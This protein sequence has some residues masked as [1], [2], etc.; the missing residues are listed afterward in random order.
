MN[1]MKGQHV[2]LETGS[3]ATARAGLMVEHGD[4]V[5]PAMRHLVEAFHLMVGV[6]DD[7][8]KALKTIDPTTPAGKAKEQFC[9]E[10]VRAS[11]SLTT[12]VA[13]IPDEFWLAHLMGD[14]VGIQEIIAKL[15]AA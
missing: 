12:A 6:R 13:R 9:L 2:N 1:S 10:I 4:K 8:L 11:E 15:R 5:G 14:H 3:V 7:M